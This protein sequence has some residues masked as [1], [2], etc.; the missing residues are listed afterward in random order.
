MN[1]NEKKVLEWAERARA[2]GK[3][4]AEYPCPHCKATNYSMSPAHPGEIYD[5]AVCC[6]SC[7][8]MHFK[9][10]RAGCSVETTMMG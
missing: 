7:S 2:N 6:P 10:V 1:E 9:V 3:S 5:S 4:V 8:K